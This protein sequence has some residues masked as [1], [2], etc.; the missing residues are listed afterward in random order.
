M[1]C[2]QK[3]L[4]YHPL[5]V[6]EYSHFPLLSYFHQKIR[7]SHYAAMKEK[8]KLCF[9]PIYLPIQNI[10]DRGTANKQFFKDGLG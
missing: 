8:T 5:S 1:S 6:I 2:E 9:F 4:K 10:Q 3:T 7:F